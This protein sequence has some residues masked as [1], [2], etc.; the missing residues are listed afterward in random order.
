MEYY[1]KG[2]VMKLMVSGKNLPEKKASREWS[3][4][5]LGWF[6]VVTFRS[7]IV[8]ILRS[9]FFFREGFFLEPKLM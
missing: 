2:T 6:R 3:G 7:G 5:G 1:F 9:G 8:L 4:L